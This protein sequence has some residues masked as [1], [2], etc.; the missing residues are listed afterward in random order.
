MN[1]ECPACSYQLKWWKLFDGKHCPKCVSTLKY[2][3]HAKELRTGKILK[4][5]TIAGLPV[6]FVRLFTVNNVTD[7]LLLA[8]LVVQSVLLVYALL[9]R[10]GLPPNWRRYK[11][12]EKS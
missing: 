6:F 11:L 9:V 10:I 3:Q 7:N 2:N 8:W 4:V 12:S 5:G 1:Y